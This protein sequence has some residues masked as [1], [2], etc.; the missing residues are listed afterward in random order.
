V[1]TAE[2][3]GS[4][5]AEFD[6]SGGPARRVQARATVQSDGGTVIVVHDVTEVRRLERVRRDF[7]ANVSHELRTPISVIR[8]NTE[9][10]L[11]GAL[12]DPARARQF[13]DA[14]FRHAD[15]LGRLVSDLLDISRIEAGRYRLDLGSASVSEAAERVLDTLQT[16]ADQK[17]VELTVDV[18]P[19]IRITAD[20]KAL[21]HVLMNLVGNAIKYTPEGGHVDVKAEPKGDDVRVEV[22]DDGP[23]ID[24]AHRERIFE[25]FYRVDPGRSRDMGGTGLGLSIAKHLVEAM[26]GEVGVD[27]RSPHG[28]VFWF[29]LARGATNAGLD[30]A[31]GP[32]SNDVPDGDRPQNAADSTA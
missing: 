15:R 22:L 4:T 3:G 2:R 25:R 21:E 6:L 23:G 16:E 32:P 31:S 7:V 11:E 24:P 12:D 9:T 30:Q 5:S 26:E 13:V 27:P 29:R 8:A 10:L 1:G 14:L 28:S 18:S 20:A 17:R 19:D